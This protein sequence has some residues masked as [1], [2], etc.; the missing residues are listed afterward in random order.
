VYQSEVYSCATEA[1]STPIQLTQGARGTETTHGVADFCAQAFTNPKGKHPLPEEGVLSEILDVSGLNQ[2][3]GFSKSFTGLIDSLRAKNSEAV[4]ANSGG[5]INARLMDEWVRLQTD[6]GWSG[7]LLP[8]KYI[9]FMIDHHEPLNKDGVFELH[10]SFP[11]AGFADEIARDKTGNTSLPRNQATANIVPGVRLSLK[12]HILA[13]YLLTQGLV[14]KTLLSKMRYALISMT[15]KANSRTGPKSLESCQFSFEVMTSIAEECAITW[16]EKKNDSIVCREAGYTIFSP[17][18]YRKRLE[19]KELYEDWDNRKDDTDHNISE[20]TRC[21]HCDML[22][23]HRLKPKGT[24]ARGKL[25]NMTSKGQHLGKDANRC[26]GPDYKFRYDRMLVF[27]KK[28]TNEE[29]MRI[30]AELRQGK[31]GQQEPAAELA[32]A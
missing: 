32:V 30:A 6:G 13:H 24:Q 2:F 8:E 4:F 3:C 7:N 27:N 11:V 25:Y 26:V 14:D 12:N 28:G 31:L 18:V 10:H 29:I 19:Q 20:W 21:P 5:N 17:S 16:Q 22:L 9:Q 1:N 23:P 15:G